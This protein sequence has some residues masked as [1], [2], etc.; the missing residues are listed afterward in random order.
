MKIIKKITTAGENRT[1]YRVGLLQA[2]AYRILRQHTD[3]KL[4]PFDITSTHWALLGLLYDTKSGMRPSEIANE[5]GVEA[6]LVTRLVNEFKK[7]KIIEQHQDKSDS[8][9]NVLFLTAAGKAEV[10]KIETYLRAEMTPLIKDISFGD[11]LSYL[12]VLSKI[13]ENAEQKK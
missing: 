3:K 13:I 9:A 5:L 6:P 2:K 8:R 4:M 1:T 11:L 7:K 12:L 10:K